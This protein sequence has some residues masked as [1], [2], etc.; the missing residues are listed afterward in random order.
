MNEL[1]VGRGVTRGAMTVFPLWGATG[2]RRRYT[3]GGRD[4]VVAELPEGP[5]VGHLLVANPARSRRWCWRASSS[6]AAG[7]TGWRGTR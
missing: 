5:Q 4:L 1:H 3:M 6:R 7:S 2:G